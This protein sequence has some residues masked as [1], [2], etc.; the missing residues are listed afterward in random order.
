MVVG[1]VA[2]GDIGFGWGYVCKVMRRRGDS[3][4]RGCGGISRT[5]WSVGMGWHG[6]GLW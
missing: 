6:E 2:A 3:R 4:G 1:T 5:Y